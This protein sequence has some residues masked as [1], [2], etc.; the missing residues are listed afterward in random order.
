[1]GHDAIL[2]Q[3]PVLA[4]PAMA[5]AP[6]VTAIDLTQ[7]SESVDNA[8]TDGDRGQSTGVV[9]TSKRGNPTSR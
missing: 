1:V 4:S 6:P 5:T 2:A 9:A 8:R 7:L 3:P